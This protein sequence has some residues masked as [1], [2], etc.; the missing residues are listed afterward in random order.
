MRPWS[1]VISINL[2]TCSDS[3]WS[4]IQIQKVHHM[5]MW[6]RQPN[7]GVGDL[8]STVQIDSNAAISVGRR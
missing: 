2:V 8:V 7:V 4:G 6:Q 3:K 1:V 5:L